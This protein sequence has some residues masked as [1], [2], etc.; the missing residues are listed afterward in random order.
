M[1]ENGERVT[2]SQLIAELEKIK[3]RDG[4]LGV[5]C[6]CLQHGVFERWKLNIIRNFDNVPTVLSF[7]E[8]D[9]Y[10][11]LRPVAL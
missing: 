4:D 6:R 3:A 9:T 8:T 5:S 2:I 11:N 10:E 7:W 1:S